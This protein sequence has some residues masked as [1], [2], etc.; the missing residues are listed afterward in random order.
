MTMLAAA[1]AASLR[2]RLALAL[3]APTLHA[4]T[5]R[6]WHPDDLAEHYLDYLEAMHGVIRASVPLMAA[7][8][9]RCTDLAA[10]GDRV[11]GPLAAYLSTHLAE[12]T[13]HDEWLLADLTAA[14]RD[15]AA[16]RDRQPGPAVA[17]LA[18]AQYY[19]IEHHH[20]VALLG[21]IA[22]L[23]GNAPPPG[24][25]GELATRTGL[26]PAAFRTL[27]AHADL[28]AGHTADLDTLL[29]QLPLTGD[30]LTSVSV[31]ALHT[32]DAFCALLDTLT[33]YHP[34]SGKGSR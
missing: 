8:A 4:A 26:P 22:V 30:H 19:W 25:A 3:A 5:A 10:G 24:L 12:E 28:D 2:L 23:E 15:T 20:P 21:Y 6:L 18:G 9:R 31:S 32:V 27:A 17:R 29:D 7:A 33:A 11:A 16:A 13:G 1:P 14:G 34:L